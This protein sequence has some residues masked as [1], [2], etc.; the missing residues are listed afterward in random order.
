MITHLD[1][2]KSWDPD[3]YSGLVYDEANLL[4]LPREG[5][6]A[7]LTLNHDVSVHARYH[8]ALLNRGRRVIFT[9]NRKPDEIIL[10]GDPAIN[11]RVQVVFVNA[12]ND[13]EPWDLDTY[14]PA[15]HSK[16]SRYVSPP[17]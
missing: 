10:F 9:T 17:R 14:F 8:P 1:D 16:A 15:P 6:L 2:L 7:H 12:L 4:H 3:L 5:Q 13:Y 11:R